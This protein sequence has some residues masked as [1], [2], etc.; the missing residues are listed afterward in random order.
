MSGLALALLF[1]PTKVAVTWFGMKE[2]GRTISL[3][4][5]SFFFGVLF[6]S[7]LVRAV[8]P[9]DVLYAT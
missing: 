1:S 7:L 2:R 8:F 3:K 4:S 5:S 9:A 6:S